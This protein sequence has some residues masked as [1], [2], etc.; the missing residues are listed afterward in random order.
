MGPVAL[1]AREV[2]LIVL[3]WFS[4]HVEL[5]RIGVGMPQIEARIECVRTLASGL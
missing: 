5:I 2:T 3:L 1:H 4:H